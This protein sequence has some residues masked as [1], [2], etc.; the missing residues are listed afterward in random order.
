MHTHPSLELYFGNSDTPGLY[1]T[2]FHAPG[3]DHPIV[4]VRGPIFHSPSLPF[5]WS[6]SCIALSLLFVSAVTH[7]ARGQATLLP[8]LEGDH[9][10]PAGTLGKLLHKG[11]RSWLHDIFGSDSTGRPLLA[12]MILLSNARSRRQGPV[13]ATLRSSYLSP[14]AI[15]IFV[16]GRDISNDCAALETLQRNLLKEFYLRKDSRLKSVKCK[17]AGETTPC[18]A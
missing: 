9:L 8:L 18:A 6:T 13:T 12:R 11:I 1:R 14:T 7:E 10:S 15:K 16:D 3:Y 4:G 5:I 17:E 2:V